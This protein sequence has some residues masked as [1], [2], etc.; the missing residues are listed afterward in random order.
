[1]KRTR[2]TP[3]TGTAKADAYQIITD[4]IL[5]K[6]EGG[7]IPWQKPWHSFGA[8]RNY[9]TGHVY[10]GI[11]A[12]LLH[13]LSE[14]IPLFMTFRQAKQLGG[15]I[16]QGAKGFP[17]IYYNVMEK[18]TEEGKTKRTPFVNYCTVF[19]IADVEGVNLILP[20]AT[21]QPLA[22][23]EAAESIVS[24]WADRPRITHMDQKAYYVPALDYVNMPAFSSFKSAEQY[25]QTLFHELTH[26][27]GHRARLNR[28]D[29][30]DNMA[31][32]GAAGYAREELTAE[33]GAAFLCGAA[34]L[35]PAATEENT[36]AY[37]QTWIARLKNDKKLLVQAASH[38]QKAANLI[39]GDQ[40]K[41]DPDP[42]QLAQAA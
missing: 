17:I 2:T 6:M 33:M 27:T 23:I 13:F 31:T 4:R 37:L 15:Y 32:K 28:T 42:C 10:T 16:R 39:L 9:V 25:Y 20:E 1:M 38:A 40:D 12:F 34:G 14:G 19:N 29:L 22:P 41:P 21:A 5:V 18:E 30:A 36:V 3:G 11:N 7:Q 24:S 26:S 35:D 8:P